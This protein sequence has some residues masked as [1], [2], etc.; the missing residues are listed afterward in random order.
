MICRNLIS[1]IRRY[2][3]LIGA[4]QQYMVASRLDILQRTIYGDIVSD[5]DVRINESWRIFCRIGRGH[6]NRDILPQHIGRSVYDL[7]D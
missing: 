3:V 1:D 4:H 7:V 6:I 2:I 5:L